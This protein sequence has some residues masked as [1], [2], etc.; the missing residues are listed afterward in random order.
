MDDDLDVKGAVDG[1][2]RSLRGLADRQ[3]RGDLP[4]VEAR[5]ALEALRRVDSVLQVIFPRDKA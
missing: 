5:A 2:L 1:I 3:A 4:P